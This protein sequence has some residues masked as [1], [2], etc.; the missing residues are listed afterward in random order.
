MSS[1]AT[2]LPRAQLSPGAEPAFLVIDAET[3]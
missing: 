3:N 2:S 1:A